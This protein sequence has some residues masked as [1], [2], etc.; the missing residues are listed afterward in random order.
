MTFHH[1]KEM[2]EVLKLA[3]GIELKPILPAVDDEESVKKKSS[4]KNGDKEEGSGS[5]K[6]R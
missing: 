5:R 4:S 1:V 6:S 2:S 3:L